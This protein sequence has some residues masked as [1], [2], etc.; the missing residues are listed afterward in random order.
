MKTSTSIGAVALGAFLSLCGCAPQ[1]PPK[2]LQ[3]NA[4]PAPTAPSAARPSRPQDALS[5]EMS[6]L[7]EAAEKPD[8]T[9]AEAGAILSRM[10]EIVDRYLD[11][12]PEVRSSPQVQGA[13]ERMCD[14][15]LQ[16]TLDLN[17]APEGTEGIAEPAPLDT[18]L[19]ET[20]F[21]SPEDLARVYGEVQKVLQAHPIDFPVTVND[22][23]LGY[24]NLYQT[25]LRDWFN[26]A[27][28]RGSPYM[29]RMKKIFK[30]EGI[31]ATLA[32]LSI[33]ESAC[34]P[35][36][37]S[38]AKAAGMW[39]FIAGTA[40]RYGLT[41]DFWE[42]ERFDP[43]RSAR[44][45]ARY[46]KDLNDNFDDWYL[47]LAA[48]N[49]GEGRIQ[50][51]LAHGAKDDFWD[52]RN[53]RS[54]VRET[55][56]Y[57]PA[58]LAAILVASDPAAY[59]FD[60]PAEKEL[61]PV[62]E[63]AIPTATDLRVLA[64]CA[65]VPLEALQALNPSLRRL[66]TPPRN[67][68]LRIPS[69]SKESFVQALADVPEEERVAVKMHTVQKGETLKKVAQ[70]YGVSSEAIR[71]AN[72]LPSRKVSA[73]QTLVIPMGM[74][75]SDPALFVESQAHKKPAPGNRVYKVRKGDSLASIARKTGVPIGTLRSLNGLDE[76]EGVKPGQRLVLA[77]AAPSSP[78]A[79]AKSSKKEKGV[80]GT[81]RVHH[82]QR[83]ETLYVVARK[84]GVTVEQISRAN[85]ISKGKT[86]HIGD[87]LIIP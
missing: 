59:G 7:S 2:S 64:R 1:A 76:G 13:L 73:G 48:Y 77:S 17:A 44:A 23:V 33:V 70:R 75:A 78:K 34:N 66:M 43:E 63:V 38:R 39:Q 61:D 85:R 82:V 62:E 18:I 3:G 40:K 11:A 8:L 67:Y 31:P 56:E 49:C 19:K 25:R 87:T 28:T 27:L 15:S 80:P 20:T 22:A 10:D 21:L 68:S 29:P 72:L 71:M 41:V 37:Y 74:T 84:Y 5:E 32:Y 86:L 54:L 36:A 12:P 24:V 35:N 65:N 14:L 53:K 4:A 9:D 57:V 45:S 50:K 30:E 46:L 6:T 69:G 60:A 42:D 16:I 58:I 47:A 26:R 52:M 81:Q 79:Q 51:R 55:R 83:G